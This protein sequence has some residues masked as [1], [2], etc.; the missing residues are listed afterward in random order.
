MHA[1]RR[2]QAVLFDLFNTLVPG[3]SRE[4]RDHVSRRM[5]E[6]LGVPPAAFAER[7]RATFDDRARGRL[8]DLHRTLAHLVGGLGATPS[9]EAIDAAV[10]LRL[11]L[12][13]SLHAQTWALPALVELERLGVLRALV[14]DCS[15][16]TPMIWQESPLSRHLDAVSF[17]CVTG[18][19][20][21][22]PEAYL[23]AV[24]ALDV[25]PS[26]CIFIGD[27]GSHEPSGAAAL[28]M[29]AIRF[30]PRHELAGAVIDQ[31]S[32]W[33]GP[34]LEDLMALAPIFA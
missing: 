14:T 17:S 24:E 10:A 31:D 2:P 1:T 8:G 15:A 7:V 22:E 28:G 3:G 16:E 34:Y 18:H 23:H 21:P 20:K 4:E 29:R 13:R 32:G 9:A 27:G 26:E 25:E 11:D 6:I 19:R 30:A 33:T 12:T 5:A